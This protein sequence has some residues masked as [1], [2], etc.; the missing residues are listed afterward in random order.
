MLSLVTHS[1][2]LNHVKVYNYFDV[3][4]ERRTKVLEMNGNKWQGANDP[5]VRPQAFNAE[6][7]V[8]QD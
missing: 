2:S 5:N 7:L 8:R 6:I 3:A 4:K 1:R